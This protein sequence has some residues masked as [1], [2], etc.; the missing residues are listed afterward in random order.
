MP[1]VTVNEYGK[2]KAYYI[3]TRQNVC[4]LEK[5]VCAIS[6]KVGVERIV[7]DKLPDGVKVISRTDYDS[8]YVFITNYTTED[9]CV[10]I[11]DREV[12]NLLDGK[13]YRENITLPGYGVA[14]LKRKA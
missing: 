8:E 1:S 7:P 4:D 14:V 3:A 10:E 13:T 11:G 6:D 12:Y 5:L 2:G 9:R